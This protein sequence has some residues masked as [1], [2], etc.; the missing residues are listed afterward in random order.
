MEA[1][2]FSDEDFFRTLQVCGARALLIGRRALIALGA[3]VMTA[4]YDV[5]LHQDDIERL[6]LAFEPF[7]HFP[8]RARPR[9]DHAAA[10]PQTCR[11][12]ARRT[13]RYVLEYGERIDVMVARGA[14]TPAGEVL[15]FDDA[16]T[17]RVAVTVIPGVHGV[18]VQLPCI[19]DLILTKRWGSRPRDEV[20]VAWLQLVGGKR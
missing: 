5:W 3:P 11:H 16:W 7:A 15:T 1:S 17:R 4:D 19:D 20:D 9:V 18:S 13:G 12:E 14:T 2:E 6:N 10:E 8:N